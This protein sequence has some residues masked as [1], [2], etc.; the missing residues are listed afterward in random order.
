MTGIDFQKLG[1]WNVEVLSGG[2]NLKVEMDKNIEI[3]V[4][5]GIARVYKRSDLCDEADVNFMSPDDFNKWLHKVQK[6]HNC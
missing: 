5:D 3:Y 6:I 1:D 4:Q 2:S